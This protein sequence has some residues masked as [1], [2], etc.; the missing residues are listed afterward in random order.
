MIAKT[1]TEPVE[2][3]QEE[4]FEVIVKMRTSPVQKK[5]L[6]MA[7]SESAADSEDNIFNQL[8]AEEKIVQISPLFP[9]A[10]K[11]S[12]AGKKGFK[13]SAAAMDDAED[14]GLS[15]LNVIKFKNAQDAAAS[16]VQ[17]SQSSLVEYAHIP[18][19]R[20]FAVADPHQNRQWGLRAIDYFNAI[21]ASGFNNAGKVKVAILDSG[22]DP[23]HPDLK[24]IFSSNTNLST[25]GNDDDAGHGTHV[26]GI[27]AAITNNGIGITG[28]CASTEIMVL[29]GLTDPYQPT[30]YYNAIRHAFNNGAQ[31]LNCSLGGPHDPT[32]ELLI[33]TAISKGVV[34]VAAMGNDYQKG[35]PTSYPAALKDV[36]AVGASNEMDKR[37]DFSQTGSH[38]F[39][40][41]PGANIISTVPTYKIPLSQNLDYD[42][43]DGTSMA[44]PFV[45]AAV[46]LLLA[47]RPGATL[48]DIKNALQKSAV[49]IS[50]QTGF[51]N[52]LGYGLLNITNA[53]KLI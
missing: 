1:H 45:A 35:N 12:L 21:T 8:F 33:R 48:A 20:K 36:I 30:A 7:A 37:A 11:I 24:G 50:G 17:M 28:T 52:E 25:L 39:I 42:T 46:A 26:A 16:V 53:L 32:E 51:T 40:M 41:A 9:G 15:G 2:K 3:I 13:K 49:K 19:I 47:K 5:I 14:P 27:I 22:I 44:T 34:V 38:I 10:E 29:R 4:N 18:A 6:T 43:W 31:V 23:N